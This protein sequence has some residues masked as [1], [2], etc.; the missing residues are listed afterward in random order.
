LIKN[1]IRYVVNVTNIYGCSA[2]DSINIKVF[3][4]DAQVFIPNGFSPDGDGIND[5][6]M[7]RGKGILSVK[8]FRIFNTGVKWF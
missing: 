2:S 5:I 6:L 4:T 8:S 3:C 7:V 1:D